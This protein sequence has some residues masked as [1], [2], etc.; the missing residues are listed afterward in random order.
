MQKANARMNVKDL[1][2]YTYILC[3]FHK[4]SPRCQNSYLGFFDPNYKMK[5][6]PSS[7]KQQNKC[8]Q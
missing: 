7:L 1:N 3:Q 6:I 5:N 8:W 4:T 2:A